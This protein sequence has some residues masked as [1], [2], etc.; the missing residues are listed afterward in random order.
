MKKYSILLIT[1]FMV[2]GGIAQSCLPQGITFTTQGQIDN[3]QINYPNCTQIEGYVFITGSDITNLNGLS[4]LTSIAD[5][6]IIKFTSLTNLTGLDNLTSIGGDIGIGY[7]NVLTSLIG[8]GNLTYLD[9]SLYIY[10]NYAL[11]SL[12]GL[13]NITSIGDYLWIDYNS[14]LTSL[15]GLDNVAS[16]GSFLKIE[17]NNNLTSLT[18]IENLTYIGGGMTISVCVNLT[19]LTELENLTSIGG[20]LYFYNC[21][22]LNSLAG[23]HNLTSIGGHL[24]FYYTGLSNLTGL[25]N[26]TSIG[27]NLIIYENPYLT[28]LTGLDNID[29]SSIVVLTIAENPLLSTCAVQS[30]CDY[31]AGNG[32]AAIYNN[33][34]GCNSEKEIESACGVG[35][36][37]N[38]PSKNQLNIFPN[39]AYTN[40]TIET[41]ITGH[42]YILNLNG[43]ELLQQ[44][45]TET[46]TTIDI[47]TLPSGVYFIKLINNK[48]VEVG[49]LIKK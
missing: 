42:L 29:A 49:K 25:E 11:T 39:P 24:I 18:G 3:F 5:S 28:S 32:G 9:S 46:T 27:S 36:E 12:T 8:L 19:N 40:I 43:Q 22:G 21:I 4:V 44:E 37:E 31:L 41:I 38:N 34:S 13:N 1:L 7:N 17:W 16:I 14:V 47:I 48:T 30:I 20:F 33:A 10:H 6:L 45:I 35:M 23:L 2:N 15:T 26:L